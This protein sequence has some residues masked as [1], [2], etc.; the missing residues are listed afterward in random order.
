MN[1]RF[2]PLLA[3]V[4]ALSGCNSDGGE[5][6]AIAAAPSG[7]SS[8]QAEN[9]RRAPSGEVLET[10]DAAG[11]TY[12]RLQTA[13][14]REVWIAG[15]LTPVQVGATVHYT[16]EMPMRAFHSKALQ[17]DFDVLYFQGV[18]QVEG[19]ATAPA[20]PHSAMP[21]GSSSGVTAGPVE[22]VEP[23]EGGLTIAQV[24]A[25]RDALSGQVV[26]VRGK[27]VKFTGDVLGKNWIHIA[28][29]STGED[30]TVTLAE[31]P[32]VGE[33]V[34]VEGVLT[35]DKDFGYGYVYE[36]LLED[37]RLVP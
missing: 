32:A 36:I 31:A 30:L 35:L 20:S 34:E 9:S 21:M 11:Y 14:G 15:P 10:M 5:A 24:Y 8:P 4:L 17:R 25:R 18:I 37:A 6:V 33:V 19:V 2:P 28:D 13:D 7:V 12:V 23:A 27:V 1:R 22:G 29:S 26:R 3:V 16:E